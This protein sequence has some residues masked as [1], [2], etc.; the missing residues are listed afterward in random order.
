MPFAR[1]LYLHSP[2]GGRGFRYPASQTG[3]RERGDPP[4]PAGD[5]SPAARQSVRSRPAFPRSAQHFP[6][7]V[8]DTPV[9]RI[10]RAAGYAPRLPDGSA[11]P[12]LQSGT[13]RRPGV[14]TGIAPRALSPVYNPV[15]T[16]SETAPALTAN[17][18]RP[19][20]RKERS[21][22]DRFPR[23]PGF[24]DAPPSE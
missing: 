23:C 22:R 19:R 4:A 6:D 2:A 21:R 16:A 24:P 9:R 10:L 20:K 1:R 7:P 13:G 12:P 18:P 11:G 5:R 17:P 3:R 15:P 14:Q 8:G